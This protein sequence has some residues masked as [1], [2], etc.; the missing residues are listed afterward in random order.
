MRKRCLIPLLFATA[1]SSRNSD[2]PTQPAEFAEAR[3]AI[4][5]QLRDPDSAKFGPVVNRQDGAVCGS[6]NARNGYGG[7]TGS[8]AFAWSPKTGAMFYDYPTEEG[9]WRERGELARRFAALGCSISPDQS[10]AIAAVE[11]LEASDHR[12][13]LDTSR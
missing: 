13:G 7:F 1:C 12:L 4:L 3:A 10:K 2:A 11:A 6:V 8:Q 9:H 5:A